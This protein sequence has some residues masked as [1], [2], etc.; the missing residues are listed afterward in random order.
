MFSYV[1]LSTEK[2]VFSCL[3]TEK[4]VFSCF[5]LSAEKMSANSYCSLSTEIYEFS[6]I[7]HIKKKKVM[8]CSHLI[9]IF[10]YQKKNLSVF[11]ILTFVS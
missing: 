2:G 7:S 8:M 3:S 5:S 11:S 10:I 6:C 4:G 9:L 1:S